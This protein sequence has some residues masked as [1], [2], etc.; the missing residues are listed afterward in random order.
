MKKISEIEKKNENYSVTVD[1]VAAVIVA[2]RFG[3]DVGE[4]E[5]GLPLLVRKGKQAR[6]AYSDRERDSIMEEWGKSGITIQRYKGLGEMNAD[7]LRDTV[8]QVADGNPFNESLRRVTVEDVHHA[9][10]LIGTLMGNSA[11]QRRTWLLERWRDEDHA[12]NGN[13]DDEDEVVAD[14]D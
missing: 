13:G 3:T 2:T 11:R 6:Y 5:A 7:Q 12:E 8:F 4:I 14:A 10:Q 1:D 9:N